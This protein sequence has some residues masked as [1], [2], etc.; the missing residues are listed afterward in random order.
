VAAG[1]PGAAEA[2]DDVSLQTVAARII[3]SVGG[4]TLPTLPAFGTPTRTAP[5]AGA[6]HALREPLLEEVAGHHDYGDD[7]GESGLGGAR[8]ANGTAAPPMA[9]PPTAAPPTAAPPAPAPA[10]PAPPAPVAVGG[11][12]VGGGAVGGAATGTRRRRGSLRY[13]PPCLAHPPGAEASTGASTEDEE[14]YEIDVLYDE[15]GRLRA[16]A[17]LAPLSVS[18][19]TKLARMS[20]VLRLLGAACVFVI[21]EGALAGVLTRVGLFQVEKELVDEL[22]PDSPDRSPDGHAASPKKPRIWPART[23]PHASAFAPP[24]LRR[25]DTMS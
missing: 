3:A 4:L 15:F 7:G 9:A 6:T 11:G 18:I 2:L 12:A 10:P 25:Y 14:D 13:E 24:V 20:Y 17:D 5:D 23:S 22:E 1:A 8:S 21:E 16:G 19:H